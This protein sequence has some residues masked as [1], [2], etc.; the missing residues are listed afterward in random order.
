MLEK[1]DKA[2]RVGGLGRRTREEIVKWNQ[3]TALRFQT[4][5]ETSDIPGLPRVRTPVKTKGWPDNVV[6]VSIYT[7]SRTLRSASD[8]LSLQ[9]PR[10]R[11]STVG[12][13]TFSVFGPSNM[14]WS[15]SSSSTETLSGLLQIRPQNISLSKTNRLARFFP[16]RTAVSRRR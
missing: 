11:L 8:T 16:S 10:T 2:E 9:I 12:F 6:T 15:S 3:T 1:K 5:G 4:E 14:D 13:R 7:P